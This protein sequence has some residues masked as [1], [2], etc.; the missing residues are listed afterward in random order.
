[1]TD[2]DL[3]ERLAGLPTLTGVPRDQLEWLA[4]HGELKQF[5]RGQALY[6]NAVPPP[7]CYVVLSGRITV[8]AVSDGMTRTVNEL[9]PG[10][11][12]GRLPFSRMPTEAA[13][14]AQGAA[15]V[16]TVAEE[17]VD[18]LMIPGSD[19]REIARQCYAVTALCVHQMIDRTRLF[20]SDDLQ[21]EKMASL[22][23]LAAGLAHELNHPSSAAARGA[24]LMAACRREA[25][26]AT[27]D[28]CAAGLTDDQV[29]LVAALE[30]KAASPPAASSALDDAHR[31]EELLDWVEAR[32]LQPD[33]AEGLAAGAIAITD[34]DAIVEAM[35]SSAVP[36]VLRY[37]AANAMASR[38]ATELEQATRRIDLLVSTVKRHTH[39]DRAAHVDAID[40]ESALADTLALAEAKA[41]GKTVSLELQVDPDVSTVPGAAS[42]LN[43]AWMHLI[44]NAI[45]AAPAGGR[46]AVNVLRQGDTIC[47]CVADDGPGIPAED[48]ARV[49]EPFFTTKPVG[50]GAGLGL[51]VVQR[52]VRGHGGSVELSS[53]PGRTEFRVWLPLAAPA[54]A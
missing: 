20:K 22:G 39:M 24:R 40:L 13:A 35:P 46:V 15:Q 54:R 17:S 30:A 19:V 41:R 11:V 16:G 14:A 33:M 18:I 48:H 1:V 50:Q 21:R 49:F 26:A 2:R 27:R 53:Q 34:L 5:D 25:A 42:Q 32:G 36:G 9:R 52:V 10:D 31:E 7:G 51:D 23:R 45:D 12:S 37:L 43:D 29:A 28:M 4:A 6:S 38:L 47:V 3:V 44:D 8:R